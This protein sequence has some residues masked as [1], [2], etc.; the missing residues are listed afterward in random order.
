MDTKARVTI[1]AALEEVEYQIWH[2]AS[3][4]TNLVKIP[5]SGILNWGG[6]KI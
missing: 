1:A 2:R 4:Q 3:A 5:I 6:N